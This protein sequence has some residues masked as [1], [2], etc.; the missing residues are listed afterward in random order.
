[1]FY[2]RRYSSNLDFR[3]NFVGVG[4]KGIE[5]GNKD[6]YEKNSST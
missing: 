2:P 1:M 4:R 6:Y 5:E 3:G